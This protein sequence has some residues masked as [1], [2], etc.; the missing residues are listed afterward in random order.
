MSFDGANS[1]TVYDLQNK[2]VKQSNDANKADPNNTVNP[3]IGLDGLH[4]FN[5]LQGIQKG[6]KL[7]AEIVGGHQSTLLMQLG[8]I[9]LRSGETLNTN[10]ANVHILNSKNALRYWTREYETGWEPTV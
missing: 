1:Y 8:N 5:F 2:V 7:N 3:S 9:A 6:T 4:I 10:P